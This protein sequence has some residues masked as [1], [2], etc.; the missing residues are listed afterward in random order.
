MVDVLLWR[1][2]TLSKHRLSVID[3]QQIFVLDINEVMWPEEQGGNS[4]PSVNYFISISRLILSLILY[5]RQ[6]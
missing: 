2:E 3:S 6:W 1:E 5:E 4:F